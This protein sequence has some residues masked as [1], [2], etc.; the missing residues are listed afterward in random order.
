M[1]SVTRLIVLA[2]MAATSGAVL[3][4]QPIDADQVRATVREMLADADTRSSLL[5]GGATSGH[6]GKNFFLASADGNFTMNFSAFMQFR[7]IASFSQNNANGTSS[8][9]NNDSFDSGFTNR[10][11]KAKIWGNFL[12]KDWGYIVEVR[13]LDSSGGGS[14]QL[15]DCYISYKINDN[16]KSQWGQFKPLFLK[17]T[18]NSDVYTMAAERSV[19]D[20]A[21]GQGRAQGVQLMYTSGEFSIGGDFTDGFRTRNTNWT[22]NGTG[23]AGG[24]VSESDFALDSRAQ[25]RFAGTDDQ[26]KDYTSKPGE[27]YAGYI[28]AAIAYE[29][30]LDDPAYVAGG[31]GGTNAKCQFTTYTVDTQVEGGGFSLYAAF[32]GANT[33]FR[34]PTR[35]TLDDFGASLQGAWRFTEQWE[36]FCRGDWIGLD[37]SRALPAGSLNNNFFVTTGLNYYIAGHSA[38]VT[39]DAIISLNRTDA[40]ASNASSIVPNGNPANSG[41]GRVLPTSGAIG[42]LGSSKGGETA[43]RLQFQGIF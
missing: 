3:A 5:D 30:G 21:F 41:A 13:M 20:L 29:Q 32:V 34:D 40:L 6:N 24:T 25:W 39:L 7:Y 12:G 15:D 23:G 1:S 9:A 8:R 26:L 16:F 22:D 35:T 31:P 19:I 17:E 33:N 11:T 14:V 10:L 28:G 38:K 43:I 18:S 27:P 37:S 36:V 2:G 42:L 4:D